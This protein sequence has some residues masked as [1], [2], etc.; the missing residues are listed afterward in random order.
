V[1]SADTAPRGKDYWRSL[2]ERRLQGLMPGKPQC[3]LPVQTTLVTAC[4]AH[5]AWRMHCA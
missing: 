2:A 1:T 3:L 5:G 4:M